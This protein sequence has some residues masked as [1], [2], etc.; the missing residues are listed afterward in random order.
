MD[1]APSDCEAGINGP[2]D[3]E[4]ERC[5]VCL[6][7]ADAS[8]GGLICV[9]CQDEFYCGVQHRNE[10]RDVHQKVCFRPTGLRVVEGK[11]VCSV[12]GVKGL[13]CARCGQAAYCS[14]E[15]QM[16]DWPH[17]KKSCKKPSVD[18]I[19]PKDDD[20]KALGLPALP[21]ELLL[22]L[23]A[24]LGPYDLVRLGQVN[25]VLRVVARDPAAWQHVTFPERK[26]S[27]DAAVERGGR[28]MMG[29][30]DREAAIKR[31][32]GRDAG[33]GVL[34]VAP[35]LGTLRIIHSWPPVNLLRHTRRVR[36]LELQWTE[37]AG[38][39]GYGSDKLRRVLEHYRGHLQVLQLPRIDDVA[40]LHFIDGLGLRELRLGDAVV[41]TYDADG[42]VRG[43]PH[44][45]VGSDVT[46]E[47]LLE[48]LR[49][50]E[51]TLTIFQVKSRLMD[52]CKWAFREPEAGVVPAL[53]RCPLLETVEVPALW[54]VRGL[55][56]DLT[57]LTALHL[58]DLGTQDHADVRR[59]LATFPL[60]RNIVNM[61]VTLAFQAH[62]GLVE[63]VADSFPLLTRLWL[64]FDSDSDQPTVD[65]MSNGAPDAPRDLAAL[66]DLRLSR[67]EVLWLSDVRV[68]CTVLQGLAAGLLPKLRKLRLMNVQLTRLGRAALV[69]LRDARP[70]LS[71]Q[72]EGVTTAR[73][74]LGW[75]GL[76]DEEPQRCDDP[77][78]QALSDCEDEDPVPTDD[79]SD[80]DDS[81]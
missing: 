16:E 14:R 12:C 7:R 74:N 51:D 45:L 73:R 41:R 72:K 44:L 59:A 61:S 70:A 58:I 60:A 55:L 9:H 57:G 67:L 80:D 28:S 11:P 69:A 29:M 21:K 76:E 36:A 18:K 19:N 20:D 56:N 1:T 35:A 54:L 2:S 75:G 33:Y 32:L 26:P 3:E 27:A 37:I 63:M 17:H 48:L 15:H 77:A 34:R 6:A 40:L 42:S 81:D 78:C 66:L 8:S 23:C 10:H 65:H 31:A 64:A 47:V 53:R 5:V 79:E 46:G 24:L 13:L 30:L 68:P 43:V 4:C 25:R 22:T 50:S 71:V 39:H 52:F 49:P 38:L 62:R